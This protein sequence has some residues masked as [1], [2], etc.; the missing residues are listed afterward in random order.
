MF[1]G[2]AIV[3]SYPIVAYALEASAIGGYPNRRLP[4]RLH[5]MYSSK[6]KRKTLYWSNS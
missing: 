1:L 5:Y 3:A 6:R 4:Y 2:R